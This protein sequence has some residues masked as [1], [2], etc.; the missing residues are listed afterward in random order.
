M[1]QAAPGMTFASGDWQGGYA[2]AAPQDRPP[3]MSVQ[4]FGPWGQTND[5]FGQRDALIGRLQQQN[6]QRQGAFN[7]F[8]PQAPQG[9]PWLDYGMAAQQ[10][11]V[12]SPQWAQQPG[13]I[14]GL[15]QQFGGGGVM[16][17]LRDRPDP[18]EVGQGPQIINGVASWARNDPS[19][20]SWVQRTDTIN[21]WMR[22]YGI[23]RGEAMQRYDDGVR[24]SARSQRDA[25]R[26]GNQTDFEMEQERQ[27]AASKRAVNPY[28]WAVMP[29][30]ADYPASPGQWEELSHGD[31]YGFGNERREPLAWRQAQ[32]GQMA[33]GGRGNSAS[34]SQIAERPR[35]ASPPRTPLWWRMALGGD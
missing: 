7:S 23:D 9:S 22:Q 17:G 14:S 26:Q 12:Y 1:P 29:R 5:P 24:R 33:I 16:G 10:A 32:P 34:T 6:M 13:P 8:G 19:M 4:A 27:R 2:S 3:P 31:S 25:W 28:G 11:G 30:P 15:N 18:A 35:V 21:E 20:Q